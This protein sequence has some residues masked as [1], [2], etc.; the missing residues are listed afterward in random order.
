MKRLLLTMAF[1]G[2]SL[3]ALAQ[4]TVNFV[5][6][7]PSA[8]PVVS[9]DVTGDWVNPAGLGNN[10][11]DALILTNVGGNTWAGTVSNVPAGTYSYKFR[12]F[13][14]AGGNADYEGVPSACANNG[15][16][17]EFTITAGGTVN[18][19][20]YCLN[21]C[22]TQCAVINAVTV[23]FTLD[24]WGVDRTIPAGCVDLDSIS[25]AGNI[26]TDAGYANW[27]PGLI[28]MSEVLPGSKVYTKTLNVLNKNYQYKFLRATNWNYTDTMA[29]PDTTYQFSEQKSNFVGDSSCLDLSSGN[30]FLDLTS[31]PA[32]AIVN[33]SYRWESCSPARPASVGKYVEEIISA[34]PNPFT[35]TTTITFSDASNI[36]RVNVVNNMGQT[37]QS[38]NSINGNKLELR[39]LATGNYVVQIVRK[40]G[41]TTSLKL[42][43]Q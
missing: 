27:S 22:D 29:N 31:Q 9:V 12:T 42:S 4:G 39:N 2:C 26:G 10:W 34:A 33:V 11:G 23:N 43:A 1:A 37:I 32:G 3:L 6:R 25:L 14:T 40:A 24:V 7:I 20:P 13:A 19:G 16:N 8:P 15:G 38:H 28:G 41:K 17:R 21:T 18:C 35:G 30:R 36:Q 5:V